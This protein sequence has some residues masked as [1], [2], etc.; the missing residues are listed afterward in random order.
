MQQ[1]LTDN[2]KKSKLIHQLSVRQIFQCFYLDVHFLMI[3]CSE[4][5][6]CNIL[7]QL[8]FLIRLGL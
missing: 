1:S 6:L 2:M 4:K 7:L 5:G 8:Y 3:R